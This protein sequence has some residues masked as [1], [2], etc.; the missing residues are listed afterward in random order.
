MGAALSIGGVHEQPETGVREVFFEKYAEGSIRDC[1]LSADSRM[2]L[3]RSQRSGFT[4]APVLLFLQRSGP[5]S[6]LPSIQAR[7]L[8]TRR[9]AILHK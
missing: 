5:S 8:Q 4:V 9:V 3:V 1:C 7:V 6:P 2:G